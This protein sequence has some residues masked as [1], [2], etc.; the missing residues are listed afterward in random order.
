MRQDI[1][2]RVIPNKYLASLY[3]INL[4][5]AIALDANYTLQSLT[6]MTI[7]LFAIF[8]VYFLIALVSRGQFGMGDVKALA[9][10]GSLLSFFSV[11]LTMY[12]LAIT[13]VLGLFMGVYSLI[14][15]KRDSLPYGVPI[16]VSA[17]TMAVFGVFII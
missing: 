8:G 5:V 15:K 14:R 10:T 12:H 4:L 6:R 9:V 7:S 11:E 13:H 2:C 17:I 1:Q 3:V 16:F